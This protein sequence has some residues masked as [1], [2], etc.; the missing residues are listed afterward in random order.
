MT[1]APIRDDVF[2]KVRACVA[3]SLALN[4]ADL[5][6]ESRLF[7]DLGASSLDFIDIIF[8]LEKTFRIKVAETEFNFLTRLDF[9]SPEVMQGGHLTPETIDRLAQWLPA[10]AGVPDRTQVTP[11]QLFSFITLETISSVIQR[12]LESP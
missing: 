5:K 6:L 10:L 1:T 11:R 2:E 3:D 12:R 8:T 9:A 4:A 7:E